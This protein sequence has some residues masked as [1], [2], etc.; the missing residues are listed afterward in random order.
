ML[1]S[2]GSPII[3]AKQEPMVG[4][5][6]FPENRKPHREVLLAGYNGPSAKDRFLHGEWVG[7]ASETSANVTANRN[8]QDT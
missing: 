4:C 7:G 1:T 2:M 8:E 3:T 6:E 5:R